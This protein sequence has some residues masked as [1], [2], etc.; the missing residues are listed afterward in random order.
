MKLADGG[1]RL[2]ARVAALQTSLQQHV[3]QLRALLPCATPLAV[4][5][6]LP[7]T[8]EAKVMGPAAGSGKP[9]LPSE[10]VPVSNAPIKGSTAAAS[11]SHVSI[12]GCP[13]ICILLG[14]ST[15]SPMF[16]WVNSPSLCCQ[17]SGSPSQTCLCQ[18][19]MASRTVKI[20][21]L[22]R[23]PCEV[24]SKA[25]CTLIFCST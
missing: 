23:A 18:H 6:H 24:I 22:I 14:A 4:S 9:A 8:V 13:A 5:T 21:V 17:G 1:T 10:P 2:A 25:H 20:L 19:G 12:Q 16:F 3:S 7:L 15:L 11:S